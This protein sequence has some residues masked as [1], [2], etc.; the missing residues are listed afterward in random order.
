MSL[1]IESPKESIRKLLEIISNYSKVSGYKINLQGAGFPA[2]WLSSCALL[3]RPRG[4]WFGS[5]V[6]T[7]HHSSGHIEVVSHIQRLEGPTTKIYNYVLG[8]FGE[9]KQKRKK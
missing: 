5:W 4:L 6:R 7:W 3:R 2:K 8:G 9:K 1:Y